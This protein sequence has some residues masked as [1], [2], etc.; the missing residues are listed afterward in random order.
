MNQY[1]QDWA[2][3][4]LMAELE[5]GVINAPHDLLGC[6]IFKEEDVQIFTAYRPCAEKI[7][8]LDQEGGEIGEMEEMPVE[9]L[10]GYV[11]T[12]K[13]DRL[14]K[15]QFRVKYG[16]DDI[17]DVEDPYAYGKTFTDFDC[18][19]FGEGKHYQIY[20]KFGAHRET[21]DGAAGTRFIV[22]AP[23]ARSV[24]VIG[25]FNMW[26]GRL[27]KMML[28]GESGIFELFIP[29]AWEGAAYKYEITARD[30]EKLYKTDPY[31]NYAELRPGNASRITSLEGYEWQDK[32]YLTRRSNK[33]VERRD[34]EPM[35]IYEVHLAS[36]KKRVEEDDNGNYSYREMAQM[37]GDYVLE[38]GYTHIE[39]MGISEYPFDGSWGYQVG[40]YYAPTS[41]YGTPDD[42]QYFVDYLHGQGI[43]VILDWVPAHFP[44]DLA[45]LA[46]FDGTCVYEHKDPRQGAHPH[47][48]T[49]I[50][51]YGR[52]QVSN[53]LIANALYWAKKYH[54]DGIRMD[55]V[56]SMLYL[57][58]GK[59]LANG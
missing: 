58:Y 45:G 55:A 59:I 23:R 49:L 22:W 50:Y 35:S 3:K 32:E 11:I 36:W 47:W 53:F 37:L 27:H 10:F 52:P 8:L 30:G 38:M 29:G 26:D 6:H 12:K 18:Y 28:H 20:E 1:L 21:V 48:G 46:C 54:A 2:G 16:E 17:I 43:G 15:Y 40:C 25:E 24:S 31:G 14:T 34:R 44:R 57:D 39:L 7:W 13:K 19:I 41:R 42:F 5:K 9:G 56:A 4:E 33:T 51:N